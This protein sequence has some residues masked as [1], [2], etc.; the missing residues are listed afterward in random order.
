[1]MDPNTWLLP[2]PQGKNISTSAQSYPAV[3]SEHLLNPACHDIRLV[4]LYPGS[5]MDPVICR[6]KRVSLNDHPKYEALSY[7]WGNDHSAQRI[8]L[9]GQE[10]RIG[11]NLW[12]ALHYL[13]DTHRPRELWLDAVCIDQANMQ[14]R[15]HQVQLM[16][17][18]YQSASR[19]LAWLGT[20]SDDSDLALDTMSI[21]SNDAHF[22]Q[23]RL[24][25][26][27]SR[28]RH[29]WQLEVG[30][31]FKALKKLMK[32]PWWLRIWCIQEIALS[33]EADIICGTKALPWRVLRSF[34][35]SFKKHLECCGDEILRTSLQPSQEVTIH[36]A[37]K[38]I[39]NR[40][41]ANGKKSLLWATRSFSNGLCSDARDKI[42]GLLALAETRIRLRPDYTLSVFVVYQQATCAIIVSE[43]NL[44]IFLYSTFIKQEPE[45]PSWVPDWRKDLRG[46]GWLLK[47]TLDF[48]ASGL[49]K[50]NPRIIGSSVLV[51][52]GLDVDHVIW[53]SNSHELLQSVISTEMIADTF[54]T[55]FLEWEKIAGTA[56]RSQ[57]PSTDTRSSVLELAKFVE[58]RSF[59]CD[60]TNP[61]S[62]KYNT[63]IKWRN[64]LLE[65]GGYASEESWKMST[66]QV[67]AQLF[68]FAKTRVFFRTRSG[69]IGLGPLQTLIG[70]KILVLAGGRTP[71]VLR[72]NDKVAIDKG[73]THLLH[74][75]I[76]FAYVEGIMKGEAIEDIVAGDTEW[77]DVY[78]C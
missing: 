34:A 46:H 66:S 30:R 37:Y 63:F 71:F 40:T 70:D 33:Q 29:A 58:E 78:I 38:L 8:T 77:K 31:R 44:D 15:S 73:N 54:S 60:D 25:S 52:G 6:L 12:V 39:D 41:R 2:D 21:L 62:V 65:A 45:L 59:A 64:W 28:N 68:T 24:L 32:R 5:Y 20:A 42:Y 19:V 76:G 1:M 47:R 50:P 16:G 61:Q 35:E 75:L 26:E 53:T 10:M 18:I 7:V 69:Y 56:R 23:S 22:N 48:R 43:Q 36:N 57:L 9:D 11:T 55:C 17:L 14:E 74:S 4:S 51:I 27:P 3:Y 67:L 72:F 49:I 13:R